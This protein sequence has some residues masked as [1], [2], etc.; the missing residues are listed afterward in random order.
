MY[1]FNDNG[2]V[3]TI[4]TNGLPDL[5]NAKTQLY[6][7]EVCYT[8]IVN[9]NNGRIGAFEASRLSGNS[10]PCYAGWCETY[11]FA[12]SLPI[13]GLGNQSQGGGGFPTGGGTSGGN[14][15]GSDYTPECNPNTGPA[16]RVSQLPP[17]IPT[18]P[19]YPTTSA[20]THEVAGR[21]V[22]SKSDQANYPRLT[23][24]V[25]NIKSM[26][27]NDPNLMAGLKIWTGLS[28][29]V[30]LNHLT[31][32][33]GPIIKIEPL[34]NAYGKFRKNDPNV[35]VINKAFVL[36]LEQANLES[37]KKATSFLLAV[38][39]LHEYVH[40]GD[41]LSGM[42][43]PGEEGTEF[44]RGVFGIVVDQTNAYDIFIKMYVRPK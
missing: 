18:T 5:T 30:I 22:M 9:C 1:E 16:E 26:V 24:M 19:E 43:F 38:T 6:T 17:C 40:Y 11:T 8:V 23:E 41:Y 7:L 12:G 33:Q 32:G 28:E 10:I 20:P 37:T 15:D 36:G 31:F 3:S 44:E 34:D 39:L 35:V 14:P 42:E 4:E 29:T 13:D 21:F 25:R 27:L 2:D